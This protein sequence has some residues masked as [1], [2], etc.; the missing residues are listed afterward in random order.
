MP[1]IVRLVKAPTVS[2]DNTSPE[3][4]LATESTRIQSQA[5]NDTKFDT[6]IERF[7]SREEI[8]LPLIGTGLAIFLLGVSVWFSKK[9]K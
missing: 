7:N 3:A 2:D 9:R 1:A 6:V 8:S 4:K 5:D